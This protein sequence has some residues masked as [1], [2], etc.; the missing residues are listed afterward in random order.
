MGLEFVA[1][2]VRSRGLPDI[3]VFCSNSV[4]VERIV[5]C[6][7]QIIVVEADSHNVHYL[8]RR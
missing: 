5:L 3:W 8:T 7:D 1:E 6:T 2:N 4:R